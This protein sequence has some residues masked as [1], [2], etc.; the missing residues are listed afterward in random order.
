M[1]ILAMKY[2]L[3]DGQGIYSYGR[4]SEPNLSFRLWSGFVGREELEV[5]DQHVRPTLTKGN[6][7]QLRMQHVVQ[8]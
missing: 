4:Q 6:F 1:Y 3:M 8:Q 7:A 5:L 2:I